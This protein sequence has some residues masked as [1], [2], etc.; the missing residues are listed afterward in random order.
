MTPE[1]HQLVIEMFKR[2]TIIYAGLVKALQSRGILD[3]G[4]LHAFDALVS[5]SSRQF[6]E[7]NVEEY[8][9]SSA[10]ILGVNTGLPPEV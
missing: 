8:Y 4:D 1:E 6:L 5:A 9:R 10:I 7:Q 3:E 2:Q